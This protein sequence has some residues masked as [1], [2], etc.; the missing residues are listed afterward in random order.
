MHRFETLAFAKY[1]DLETRVRGHSKS[2]ATTLFDRSL[3]T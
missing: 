2:L 1:H 3:M